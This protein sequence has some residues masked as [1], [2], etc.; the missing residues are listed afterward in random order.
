VI[1]LL[2]PTRNRPDSVRRLIGSARATASDPGGL[3]FVFYTDSDAPLP[4]DITSQAGVVTINGPRIVLSA[5]WNACCGQASGEILMQAADDI[6]FHT[7]EWDSAVLAEFAKVPDKILLV[8][9]D[10]GIQGAALG[11]H[12]FVH[13]RWVDTLGYFTAPYFSMDYGDTWINDL[14][15]RVGRRVYLPD[16]VTEHMHPGV[17]KAPFDQTHSDRVLR[18]QQD[19][20]VALWASLEG[21]RAAGAA[22]LQAVIDAYGAVPADG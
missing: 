9:G 19:N 2:C 21:E 17:G 20:V 8:H 18:G 6:V 22:K 11:T 10:D 5:M 16:V 4:G 3:E 15:D 1:S 13:R 12:S 7:P 14:A